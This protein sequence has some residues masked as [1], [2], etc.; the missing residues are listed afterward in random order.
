MNK[1]QF[2]A[3]YGIEYSRGKIRAPWGQWVSLPLTWGSK[4]HCYSWSILA[5]TKVWIANFAGEKAE[6]KGTCCMQCNH[7]YGCAGRYIMQNVVDGIAWRTVAARYYPEWLENA[8]KAQ[9]NWGC[10]GKALPFVRVHITGDFFSGPYIEMWK[11]IKSACPN[12]RMWA[13]TKSP[14]AENAFDN[15]DDFNIVK[16]LIPGYG[17]NYGT[18]SHVMTIYSALR[19][20]GIN[21]HIC[22]CGVDKEQHCD[23]CRACQDL[24][25][26]L[27]L[28]HGSDYKP[29]DDPLYPEFVALVESDENKRHI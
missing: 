8:I 12:T 24:Q 23:T 15:V 22:R 18:C 5:G 21:T 4:T 17:L 14:E 19:S 11:R 6:I 1:K 25:F 13:Y 28:E 10:R 7:C 9:I 26:V 3:T 16:S 27:F 20:S 29:E 2:F